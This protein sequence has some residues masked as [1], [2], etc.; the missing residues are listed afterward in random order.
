MDYAADGRK[1]VRNGGYVAHTGSDML[2]L[3]IS[4][5]KGA[6]PV[7]WHGDD[8]LYAVKEVARR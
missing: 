3:V 1:V 5:P 6:T 8:K 2:R 4:S 7:A